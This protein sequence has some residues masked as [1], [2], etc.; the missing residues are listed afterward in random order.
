MRPLQIGGSCTTA[1]YL[2]YPYKDGPVYR[3]LSKSL[4]QGK[5]LHVHVTGGTKNVNG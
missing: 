3:L 4:L 1:A 5:L 2:A